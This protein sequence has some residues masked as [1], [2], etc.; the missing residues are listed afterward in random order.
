MAKEITKKDGTKEPF[1]AGKIKSGIGAVAKEAGLA[2]DKINEII[3][4]VSTKVIAMADA[5]E[6]ITSAEIKQSI[7]AEL[8]ATEPAVSAAWR[9]YD[10]TKAKA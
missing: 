4:K 7:L 6:E 1:D 9:K 2:E 5:K 10:E 8:D 3:E